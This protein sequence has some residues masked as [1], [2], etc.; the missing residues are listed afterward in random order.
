MDIHMAMESRT[1][2]PGG[3]PLPLLRRNLQRRK[4]PRRLRTAIMRTPPM[5]AIRR[6]AAS[7]AVM[8]W[9]N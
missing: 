6:P 1:L 9:S 5:E 2:T 7:T 8:R 3:L 4:S